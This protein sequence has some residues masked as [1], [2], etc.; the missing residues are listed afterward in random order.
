MPS[1]NELTNI[2]KAQE[3]ANKAHNE[4][5]KRGEPFQTLE[6]HRPLTVE[7]SQEGS[8]TVKFL[9]ARQPDWTGVFAQIRLIAEATQTLRAILSA[10][11][12]IP[13]G[14]P[15]EPGSTQAN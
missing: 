9:C 5:I 8:A 14:F 4:A 2:M 3:E 13:D 7:I 1:L 10:S 12:K 6:A 15:P 11:E